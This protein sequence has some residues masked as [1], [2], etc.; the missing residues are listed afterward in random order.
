MKT[1]AIRAKI[2]AAKGGRRPVSVWCFEPVR[3]SGRTL[4][5]AQRSVAPAARRGARE[6]MSGF[7][8]ASTARGRG[9]VMQILYSRCC[10]IDVH[11]DSVTACVLVYSESPEPEVRKKGFST[12]FKAL[13]NL[14]LWLFAQ[15]VTHVALEST[16][17]Y[18]K[19]VWEALEGH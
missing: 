10:G 18:W 14:R 13:G 5:L 15:K 8:S 12:H 4:L 17:V 7:F 6:G 2:A 19:P 3:E 16:G 1:G 9:S 11:K